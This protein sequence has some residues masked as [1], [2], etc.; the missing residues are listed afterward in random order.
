[1][2]WGSKVVKFNLLWGSKVVKLLWG[3]YVALGS[4]MLL[5]EKSCSGEN[6]FLWGE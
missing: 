3:K 5:G 1:M 4:Q 6:M 2:L